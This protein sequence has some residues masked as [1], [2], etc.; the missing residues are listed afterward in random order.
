[1]DTIW[2]KIRQKSNLPKNM[3]ANKLGISEEKYEKTA[4]FCGLFIY[5]K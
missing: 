2:K 4:V 3:V 1:M 5:Q